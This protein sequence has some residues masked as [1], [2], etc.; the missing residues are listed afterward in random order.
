MRLQ[1]GAPGREERRQVAPKHG[2]PPCRHP[3]SLVVLLLVPMIGVTIVVRIVIVVVVV[4]VVRIVIVVVVVVVVAPVPAHDL[5]VV[6]G[7]SVLLEHRPPP[8]PALV[9]H[10]LLGHPL[11]VLVAVFSAVVVRGAHIVF[12]RGANVVVVETIADP[13]PHHARPLGEQ[14]DRRVLQFLVDRHPRRLQ[15]P[16]QRLPARL[17]IRIPARHGRRAVLHFPVG[18]L[19]VHRVLVVE[20]STHVRHRRIQEPFLLVQPPLLQ[21]TRQRTRVRHDRDLCRPVVPGPGN[22]RRHPVLPVRTPQ[23]PIHRDISI[24]L[25]ILPNRLRRRGVLEPVHHEVRMRLPPAQRPELHHRDEPRQVQHLPV[26]VPTVLD[27][28]KVK[29]LGTLVYLAPEPVLERL[30]RLLQRL[31]VR[32]RIQVRQHPHHL[33]KPVHLHQIQKLKRLHLKPKVPID[34]QQHQVRILGRIHHRRHILRRLYK[35]QPP[36]LP[37]HQR[38]RPLYILHIHPTPMTHQAPYQRRLPHPRRPV[39]QHHIRR[40]LVCYLLHHRH[41][42]TPLIPLGRPRLL[43][44]RLPLGR[45]DKRAWVPPLGRSRIL[46]QPGILGPLFP[47]LHLF[48]ALLLPVRL[49]QKLSLHD[50][51]GM[52]DVVCIWCYLPT[53]RGRL[54]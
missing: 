22:V 40:R 15:I 45:E 47:V 53:T 6:P 36:L 19:N 34:H 7:G 32:E 37:R 52:N 48:P 31:G 38:Y 14:L 1:V 50:D 29:Q 35:R 12:V 9:L 18:N 26:Q 23:V 17:T 3:H 2:L 44:L 21:L 10:H 43:Y 24:T 4:V 25:R 51:D 33:R 28:R 39:H 42:H 13:A 41:M 54:R 30:L 16:H 49:G 20:Q 27:P 46:V 5:V 8:R 11:G